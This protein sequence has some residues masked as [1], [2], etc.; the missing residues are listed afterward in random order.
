M[1]LKCDSSAI[2]GV[3]RVEIL[4]PSYMS[5]TQLDQKVA[6]YST[7][8]KHLTRL[9]LGSHDFCWHELRSGSL[10]KKEGR[11]ILYSLFPLSPHPVLSLLWSPSGHVSFCLGSEV[12][13]TLCEP[14]RPQVPQRLTAMHKWSRTLQLEVTVIWLKCADLRSIEDGPLEEC[15]PAEEALAHADFCMWPHVW[16]YEQKKDC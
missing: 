7:D 9:L 2:P 6:S 5:E 12:L 1:E 10:W 4:Q 11:R 13:W 3:V 16:Y 15:L 14:L 8:L